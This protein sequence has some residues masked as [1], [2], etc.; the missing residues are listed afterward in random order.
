M[1][2]SSGIKTVICLATSISAETCLDEWM[3]GVPSTG[4]FYTDPS[5]TDKFPVGATGIP[6]GW[7]ITPYNP[8]P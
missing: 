1:F 6:S 5:M 8:K 2:S 4:T 7:T 3:S